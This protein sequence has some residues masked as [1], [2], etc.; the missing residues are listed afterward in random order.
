MDKVF[1]LYIFFLLFEENKK[2]SFFDM[3]WDFGN[4]DFIYGF[5]IC[6]N[7]IKRNKN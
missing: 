7:E 1:G 5:I 6:F 3:F 4:C 2:E